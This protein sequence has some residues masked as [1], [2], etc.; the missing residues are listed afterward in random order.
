MKD[1]VVQKSSYDSDDE[2]EI[3]YSNIDF[4]NSLFGEHL[5]ASE[6]S[7]DALKSYYV[8]YYLAQVNNGGFSQFVYNS[9]WDKSAIEFV[10][11]GL[12][13]MGAKENL[14]LFNKSAT[15]LSGFTKKQLQA[16]MDSEYFGG[17]NERDILNSF[18][19]EFFKLQK[20]EDLIHLNHIWLK[21]HNNLVVVNYDGWISRIKSASESVPNRAERVQAALDAEP[22]Y[23]K[24]IRA[25]C[26]KENQELVRVTAGDPTNKYKGRDVLAWHFITD[27]GHHYMVDLGDSAVMF[28]GASKNE[29]AIITAGP[30]FGN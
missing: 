13:L 9:R 29:V 20:S 26:K 30:E 19:D 22:R 10:R 7:Q 5:K 4:L 27:K 15:I 11:S 14:S 6:V 12:E 18:D 25:L 28:E 24:L 16:F 8:D 2:Y 3:I 17:N 1:I 21:N 23:F